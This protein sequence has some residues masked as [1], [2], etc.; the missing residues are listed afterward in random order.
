[1]P[2]N[3]AV[4]AFCCSRCRLLNPALKLVMICRDKDGASQLIKVL[5]DTDRGRASPELSTATL[6]ASRVIA[7]DE[8]FRLAFRNA[9][10]LDL[11]IEILGR[12]SSQVHN[13]LASRLKC[14]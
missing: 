13:I 2:L 6:G 8:A 9:E 7:Q 10:G 12:S 5:K 3:P 4:R 1:M 14:V 11:V